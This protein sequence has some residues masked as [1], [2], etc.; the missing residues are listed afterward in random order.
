MSPLCRQP[1]PSALCLHLLLH[2]PPNPAAGLASYL[3]W[4]HAHFGITPADVFLQK[5]PTNF[6][7]S[8]DELW[9][10]LAAGAALVV[11]LPEAHRDVGAVMDL[12]TR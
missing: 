3:A 1:H 9:A 2:S 6:D 10:A 8:V 11:A 4:F 12:I 7:A 5:T